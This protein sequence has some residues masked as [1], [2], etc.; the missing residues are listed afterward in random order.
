M[1]DP[2]LR[3]DSAGRRPWQVAASRGYPEMSEALDPQRDLLVV[4]AGNGNVGQALMEMA[5]PRRLCAIAGD[6][7]RQ[8]LLQGIEQA[9]MAAAAAQPSPAA[10]S[11]QPAGCG[12]ADAGTA[13]GCSGP[14]VEAEDDYDSLCGV[15][16]ARQQQVAPRKCGHG[17]CGECALQL[18]RP[19]GCKPL[20]CPFCREP[21]AGFVRKAF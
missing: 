16:F 2:R 18:C 15:C 14:A 6:A 10:A 21:V 3:T 20:P 9:V 5:G 4:L 1:A 7:L 8:K 17:L 19:M 12:A 13:V 11:G